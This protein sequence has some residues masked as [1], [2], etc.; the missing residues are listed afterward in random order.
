[1][2]ICGHTVIMNMLWISM[3]LRV[4]N[5]HIRMLVIRNPFRMKVMEK[6]YKSNGHRYMAEILSIRRK[7][8]SNQSNN[9]SNGK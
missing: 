3:N 4:K 6:R 1:M 9:Q 2:Y 5:L 7:T 8:L